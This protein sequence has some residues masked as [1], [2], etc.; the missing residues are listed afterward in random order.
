MARI[1]TGGLIGVIVAKPLA[2]PDAVQSRQSVDKGRLR[3]PRI[4]EGKNTVN[5]RI[6][7]ARPRDEKIPRDQVYPLD[8]DFIY[9]LLT[10]H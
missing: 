6:S 1:S 2:V 3:S 9:I 4:I 7:E 10:R 8:I 5:G